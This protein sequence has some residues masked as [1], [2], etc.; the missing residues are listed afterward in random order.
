MGRIWESI[1]ASNQHMLTHVPNGQ[2]AS[3][4]LCAQ[5]RAANLFI[6]AGCCM[7]KE[8]NAIKIGDTSMGEFWREENLT[9]PMKLMN[10]DN[11]RAAASGSATAKENTEAVLQGGGTKLTSL[12][13]AI[14][15]H[16]DDK[17]GQGDTF[18]M[19]FEQEIGYMISFPNTGNTHYQSHCRAASE[20]LVHRS[21]YIKFFDQVSDFI[22]TEYL[23]RY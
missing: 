12:A 11:A 2:M 6:W 7:H 16:K 4:P 23:P 9:P 22:F 5:Q 21:L 14:F 19:F 3:S 10:K 15:N 18:R 13:G 20:L 17:K 8:L 1:N